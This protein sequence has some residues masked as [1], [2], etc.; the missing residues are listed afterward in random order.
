MCGYLSHTLS[1]GPGLQPRHTPC[2]NR[3]GYLLIR[4][5]VLNPLIY[6]IQ[7]CKPHS[8]FL[9]V[10]YTLRAAFIAYF[11]RK[12]LPRSVRSV[13]WMS[14]CKAKGH[15]FYIQSRHIP[16]LWVW[17][18]IGVCRR[19]ILSFLSL[20]FL[21]LSFSLPSLSLKINT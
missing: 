11:R 12:I 2:G 15:W 20:M 21:S 5:L 6:T 4:R 8:C 17:S 9:F 14:S 10:K 7:G 16:G 3:M 1:W 18:L 13:G 19:G